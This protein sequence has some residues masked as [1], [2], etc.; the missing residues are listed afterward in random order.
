V[1]Q[2]GL[3]KILSNLQIALGSGR[4]ADEL[5]TT[6][7]SQVRLWEGK[8][9]PI[10]LLGSPPLSPSSYTIE[11]SYE[12]AEAVDLATRRQ[13]VCPP[14]RTLGHTQSVS[15]KKSGKFCSNISLDT[16]FF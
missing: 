10:V 9:S 11:S 1:G 15:G 6:L 12:S 2:P 8:E 13:R 3:L 16:A 14:S 7:S 4:N 5:K